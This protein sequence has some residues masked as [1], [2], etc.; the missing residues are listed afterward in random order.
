MSVNPGRRVGGLADAR[1]LPELPAQSLIGAYYS[2]TPTEKA[3]N[4]T[5]A[6]CELPSAVG[7]AAAVDE[8]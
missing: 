3:R 7:L 6:V 2:K 5:G 8:I 4:G 1:R